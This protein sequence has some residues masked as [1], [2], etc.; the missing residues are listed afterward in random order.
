ML[1]LISSPRLSVLFLLFFLKHVFHLLGVLI[2]GRQ[3]QVK[4]IRTHVPDEH[5]DGGKLGHDTIAHHLLGSDRISIGKGFD[6]RSQK[7]GRCDTA[8]GHQGL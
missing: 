1:N 7:V 3:T 8:D 6:A 5:H 4:V 2:H